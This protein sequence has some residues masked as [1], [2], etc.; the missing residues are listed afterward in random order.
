MSYYIENIFLCLSVPLVL[1]LLFREGKQQAFTIFVI[2]GMGCCLLSAYVSS[3]FAGY[4]QA[5]TTAAIMEITPVCEEVLKFLPLLFYLL[6]FE[7]DKRDVISPAI[8]IAVGFATFEN[9]CYLT[10]NGAADFSYILI[11]G[12]SAGSL[13]LLCGIALGCGIAYVFQKKW[14]M[15]TGTI[16]ALGAC[17]VFHGI[18]NIL[19][20]AKGRWS[21]IGYL[22]PIFLIFALLAVKKLR[23]YRK[24]EFERR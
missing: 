22:F 11:R 16:G 18:Y 1:S 24:F 7:P 21:L 19:I 20:T 23:F 15:I 14:I 13:H 12:A 5:G 9:V 8:G 3:F 2:L 10:E 6:V 4:Y 17:V